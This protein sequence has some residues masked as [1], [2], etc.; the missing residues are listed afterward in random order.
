MRTFARTFA[1]LVALSSQHVSA[2]VNQVFNGV[3]RLDSVESVSEK[4]G[5]HCTKMDRIIVESPSF[6]M[7]S[8]VEEHLICVG[9]VS[10]ESLALLSDYEALSCFGSVCDIEREDLSGQGLREVQS[11]VHVLAPKGGG[12]VAHEAALELEQYELPF[13]MAS[14]D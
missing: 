13:G 7:A 9:F 11:Q 12:V 2:Q 10:G 5:P 14:K 6:P 8:E 4:L 3:E 1:I